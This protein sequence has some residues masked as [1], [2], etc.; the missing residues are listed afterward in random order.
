MPP[1]TVASLA[2]ITHCCAFDDADAGDHACTRRAVAV[3]AVCRERRELEKVASRDRSAVSMRSRAVEFAARAVLCD[4]IGTAAVARAASSRSR[5]SSHRA[6]IRWELRAKRSRLP[7]EAG[8]KRD[9]RGAAIRACLPFNPSYHVSLAVAPRYNS[10]M[11][12]GYVRPTGRL[13]IMTALAPYAG[14]WDDRLAA[15]L[16]RR[17]GFSGTPDEVVRF[18]AMNA[19]DA[20]ESLIH[21]TAP[22]SDAPNVMAYPDPRSFAMMG[23]TDM[24]K[25]DAAKTRRQTAVASIR[26]LQLW[27]LNRMLTTTAPLQEKMTFVLHGHF[28]TAAIQKGVRPNLV[29]CAESALPSVR[30]RQRARF[31]PRGEPGSCDAPLSRQRRE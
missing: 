7:V 31:D 3:H 26:D 5:S 24:S 4:G 1:L 25:R 21:F 29:T 15:H 8:F 14:P 10:R 22:P 23:A 19:H 12:S 20:A 18:A 2:T 27:W 11:A 30:A 9:S 6:V 16:L 13:D 17:A 28:T